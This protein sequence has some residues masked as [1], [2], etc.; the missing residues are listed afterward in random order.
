MPCQLTL[1]SLNQHAFVAAESIRQKHKNIG[2]IKLMWWTPNSKASKVL[3]SPILRCS[4]WTHTLTTA[5]PVTMIGPAAMWVHFKL[6]G[7]HWALLNCLGTF[8]KIYTFCT[9]TLS[10][11][12]NYNQGRSMTKLN[13]YW[14][15]NN[16]VG[17]FTYQVYIYVNK[18]LWNLC[19]LLVSIR[20]N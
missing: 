1:K 9:Y 14:K 2:W 11:S 10:N 15:L 5:P 17:I 3:D 7:L 4:T 8:V 20:K 12:K 19:P 13:L 18:T 16:I 6:R